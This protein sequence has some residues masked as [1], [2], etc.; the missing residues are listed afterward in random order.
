MT[1]IRWIK[2]DKEW[3]LEEI[4]NPVRKQKKI[5]PDKLVKC[6]KEN[7]NTYLSE[8]AQEY[9]RTHVAVL[10]ALRNLV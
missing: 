5:Y 7:P 9:N 6:I 10:K 3:K 4:R 1:L 8:I 2:R